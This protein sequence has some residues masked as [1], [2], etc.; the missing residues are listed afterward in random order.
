MSEPNYFLDKKLPTLR[1][2]HR[3]SMKIWPG[4]RLEVKQVKPEAIMEHPADAVSVLRQC[5]CVYVPL[6]DAADVVRMWSEEKGK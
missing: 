6:G 5:R 4:G 2:G 3:W 1:P